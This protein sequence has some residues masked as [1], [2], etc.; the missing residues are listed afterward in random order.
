MTNHQLAVPPYRVIFFIPILYN[1]IKK[2]TYHPVMA[3][4][5]VLQAPAPSVAA[6]MLP[7]KG[8]ILHLD[9]HLQGFHEMFHDWGLLLAGVKVRNP[10]I[11]F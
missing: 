5:N 1:S 7:D 10:Q 8:S 3:T 6:V 9:L 11:G 2:W 4:W